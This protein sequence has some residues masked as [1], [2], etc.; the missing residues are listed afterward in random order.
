MRTKRRDTPTSPLPEPGPG[1]ERAAWSLPAALCAGFAYYSEKAFPMENLGLC[2]VLGLAALTGGIGCLAAGGAWRGRWLAGMGRL[3]ALACVAL[4]LWALARWSAMDVRSEGVEWV[5]GLLWMSVAAAAGVAVASVAETARAGGSERLLIYLR[6]CFVVAA[7]AAAAYAFY[8]YFIGMDRTLARMNETGAVGDLGAGITH[9]LREKR[10][11]GTLGD[12][13]LFAAQL[14]LLAPFCIGSL[15][16]GEKPA[17]RAAGA[18][19]WAML[20]G[21][22]VLTASRGGMVAFAL[23]TAAGLAA[24]GWAWKRGAAARLAA[25]VLCAALWL[26]AD[27]AAAATAGQAGLLDRLGNISTVR[28]R[29][30][31]WAIAAKIWAAHPLAGGGP[32]RFALLYAALKSPMARESKYAHSWLMQ[33]GSDLGLIGVALSIL[34]WGGL[35]WM[36]LRA[37]RAR[38]LPERFWPLLA[39]AALCFNGLFEFALQWRAFLVPAGMLAGIACGAQPSDAFGRATRARGMIAA[40]FCLGA[41]VAAAAIGTP[42]QIALRYDTIRLD[43]IM[44]AADANDT[45][46][47]MAKASAWQPRD[48]SFVLTEARAR[49]ALRQPAQAEELLKKAA[50]LNP[51][52]AE[53][54]ATYARL[55]LS[56]N[57]PDAARAELDEALKRYPSKLEYR[58]AKA[59][60]LLGLRRDAEAREVLES[61]ETDRLPMYAEDRD[62]LDAM[63][64]SVGLKVIGR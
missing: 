40:L 16:R 34:F 37:L 45:V 7:A 23:A 38:P 29:L 35:A 12:A 27:R 62:A 10:V 21:A 57:R 53:V 28:E 24:V 33:D 17:W 47:A 25:L 49:M 18:F 19:G 59:R 50:R 4:A 55:L 9:A 54:H 64:K 6:R 11:T 43:W 36:A 22:L 13:N 44:G 46:A 20:A 56:R 3:P 48:A 60:L 58:M 2:A 8:Q 5:L 63:R 52:S 31:Y 30:F 61:I 15:G 32:G 1:I 26:A 39:L 51:Y 41:L 14:L 42:W